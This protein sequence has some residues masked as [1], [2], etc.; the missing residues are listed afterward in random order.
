MGNVLVVAEHLHGKFPKT[1]LVGVSA[2]RQQV[3]TETELA[4]SGCSWFS[5]AALPSLLPGRRM[6]SK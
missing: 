4:F 5:T 6:G 3:H 2:G 1:T